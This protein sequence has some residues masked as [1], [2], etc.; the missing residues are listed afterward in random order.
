LCDPAHSAPAR[1]RQDDRQSHLTAIAD[2]PTLL[3]A[4]TISGIL[5]GGTV[6]ISSGAFTSLVGDLTRSDRI[7]FWVYVAMGSFCVAVPVAAAMSAL[8]S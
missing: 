8:L 6:S 1:Q 7:G 5:P 2:T 4:P 3:Q